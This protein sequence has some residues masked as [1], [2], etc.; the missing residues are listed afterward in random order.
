MFIYCRKEKNIIEAAANG[1]LDTIP[2]VASIAVNLIAFIA[3]LEF[4][5]VTLEWFGQRNG[6]EPPYID[7]KLTFQVLI[8]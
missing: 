4:I 5:N 8:R 1:A 3:I 6:L 2:L 7:G